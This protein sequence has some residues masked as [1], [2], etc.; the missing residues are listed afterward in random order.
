M[1]LGTSGPA[2]APV[3]HACV[4][5]PARARALC[6]LFASVIDPQSPLQPFDCTANLK[7]FESLYKPPADGSR[8]CV[9]DKAAVRS[10]VAQLSEQNAIIF[11]AD[12]AVKLNTVANS[13]AYTQEQREFAA[14]VLTA[15]TGTAQQPATCQPWYTW[16]WLWLLVALGV[17]LI[18][19]AI[20]LGVTVNKGRADKV[21]ISQL[22]GARDAAEAIAASAVTSS[23][24]MRLI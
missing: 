11:A 20:V 10:Y 13:C 18:V 7:T 16:W 15:I 23:P 3:V 1:S 21:R 19:L 6:Q 14:E 4:L 17:L 2:P 9:L 8:A 22:Q 12:A 24:R 5:S